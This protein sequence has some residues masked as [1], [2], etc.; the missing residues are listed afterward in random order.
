MSDGVIVTG[1]AT[2]TEANIEDI[3]AVRS[4]CKLPVLVGSGVTTENVEKYLAEVDGII[5]GSYLKENGQWTEKVC[6]SRVA[7]LMK[8]VRGLLKK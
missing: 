1:I 8:K 6:P 2:G 7:E 3:R 5:I 4:H